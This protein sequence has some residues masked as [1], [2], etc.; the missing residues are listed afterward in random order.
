M[1]VSEILEQI[2]NTSALVVG[3]ICLD[4]WCRYDPALSEP[5]R[6]TGIRRIAVTRT[7][8]TP[9][10]A[11]T[12]ASNL[13][14][15][16]AKQVA[17]LGVIGEDGYGNELERVLM[18]REISAEL[19]VRSAQV[20]TFTYTKLINI[21][22]DVEDQ[23]RVDY[24]YAEP[25]PA[26]VEN[27]VLEHLRRFWP[28]FDVILVSDQAE[29]QQGGIVTPKVREAIGELAA[30]TPE[31][32]V[33]VDSRVRAEHFR[34]VILKSNRDEAE[35]ACRRAFGSVDFERLQRWTSA[36]ML[37]MTNGPEG[38]AYFRDGQLHRVSAKP[39]EKPV[40]ICGAG[41]SFSA[42]A[43]LALSITKSPEEALRFGNIVASIT[44][45]KKGTG[46]ATP[47]EVLMADSTWPAG[48]YWLSISV[49]PSSPWPPSMAIAWC[50]GPRALLTGVGA[51]TGW[52][53]KSKRSLVSGPW[54]GI[55]IGAAS[56]S[57]DRSISQRRPSRSRHTWAAG[58]IFSSHPIFA[59][60]STCRW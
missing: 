22:N 4:R 6:E 60:S 54:I 27:M 36:P 46:I 58:R 45:M 52:W 15:L 14:A 13:A 48:G 2:G 10:A 39:V 23:P 8:V 30:G 47:S 26:E 44:I 50:T 16:L 56:D 32:V 49:E 51:A 43:A 38:A 5:S 17:V 41:D 21:A 59:T 24:V 29:T 1:R 53:R 35:G 3:D 28:A 34:N 9:G 25:M 33:W 7:T 40:D 18:A 19:V 55:S 42:G 20:P 57:A 12:V 37:V 31:K 11:G